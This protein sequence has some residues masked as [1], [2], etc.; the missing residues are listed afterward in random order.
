METV[1]NSRRRIMA[2]AVAAVAAL[3]W[4][5][6][7]SADKGGRHGHPKVEK[8]EYDDGECKYEYKR[9][10][11]VTKEEVKCRNPTPRIVYLRD[12]PRAVPAQAPGLGSLRCNRDLIFGVLGGVAGGAIGSQIGKG[13]G[14]TAATIAGGLLGVLVGGGIG[15]SMDQA[16]LACFG[17]ALE[18]GSPT[19]P[20]VWRNPDAGADYSVIPVRSFEQG[21]G[22]YCR[23]Y[24]TRV[25]IGGRSEQ[26][27]GT[28]CRMPD[29]DWKPMS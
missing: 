9:T 19:Q 4:S 15:R 22:L 20:V 29:G 16:D 8:W 24:Q 23:E 12:L 26:A 14:R 5:A 3:S 2:A 1:Q 18:Y 25:M 21:G 6:P 10:P 27:Y 28:A 13:D 7:A 11:G 17:Q